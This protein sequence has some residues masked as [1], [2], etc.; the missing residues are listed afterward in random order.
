MGNYNVL[1]SA[2]AN[3]SLEFLYSGPHSWLSRM[4]FNDA[5]GAP[6]R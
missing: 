5:R 2:G 1:L 4:H 3:V 6:N